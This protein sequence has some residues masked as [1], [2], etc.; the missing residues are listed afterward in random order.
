M[1]SSTSR[2]TSALTQLKRDNRDQLMRLVT[3]HG[4]LTQSQLAQLSGLSK[5]TVSNLVRGLI[6]DGKVVVEDTVHGGRRAKLVRTARQQGVTIGL[7]IVENYVGLAVVSADHTEMCAVQVEV[8]SD[9]SAAQVKERCT[10]KLRQLFQQLGRTKSD[11]LGIGLGLPAPIDA[12][13]N[14]VSME[15]FLPSWFD[16]QAIIELH[17]LTDGP[18]LLGNDANFAALAEVTFGDHRGADNLIYVMVSRGIGLGMI[19]NGA[20]Y[21]G[22]MGFAGELGHVRS[23]MTTEVCRCGNRG[24]LEMEIA[25][26][27]IVRQCNAAGYPCDSITDVMAAVDEGHM[28]VRRVV[29]EAGMTLGRALSDLTSVLNPEVIILGGNSIVTSPVFMEAATATLRRYCLP[30]VVNTI[31]IDAD[32]L[33]GKAVALGAAEHVLRHLGL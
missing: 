10:D 31:A 16:D 6:D 22:A 29:D 33:A 11:I 32:S 2:R 24:C 18:V 4:G 3:T 21:V 14:R 9:E 17:R 13:S 1:S 8:D 27:A 23:G 25:T 30:N 5:A 15:S 28:P 20:E 7:D 12:R 26:T 19:L